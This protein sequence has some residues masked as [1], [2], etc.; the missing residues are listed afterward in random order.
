MP[1]RKTSLKRKRA[2]IKRHLRN[3]KV[4]RELKKMLKKFQTL[5]S[6]KNINEAKALIGKLFSQLDKAAKKKIIHP[7]TASRNKSRLT[8]RLAKAT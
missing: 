4:K 5:I 1:R 3:L 7:N 6:A 2:D 8:K